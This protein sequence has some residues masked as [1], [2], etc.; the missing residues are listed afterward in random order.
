MKVSIPYLLIVIVGVSV[1]ACRQADGP[2]PTP[3]ADVQNELIDISRDLQNIA[4]RDVQASAELAIDLGRFWG[5]GVDSFSELSDIQ[6]AVDELARRTSSLLAGSNLTE[7]TAQQLAHN[8][9]VAVVAREMS[10]RQVEVLQN[11]FE[12]LL[13][14]A[15]VERER[16]QPMVAQVEAVQRLATTRTRRWYELF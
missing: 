4:A 5:F 7:Q 12:S 11:D 15:G 3:T 13:L 2:V 8:L 10:G 1:G 6:A 9:W 16:A 14:S